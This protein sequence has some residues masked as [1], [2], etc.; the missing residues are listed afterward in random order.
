MSLGLNELMEM[1]YSVIGDLGSYLKSHGHRKDFL[2]NPPYCAISAYL[3][4]I[5]GLPVINM[6]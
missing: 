3:D 6:D 2:P 5:T 4:Q 1:H